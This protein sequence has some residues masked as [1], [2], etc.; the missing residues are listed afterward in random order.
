[1]SRLEN[2]SLSFDS[3]TKARR[4]AQHTMIIA[5]IESDFRPEKGFGDKVIDQY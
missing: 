1:M 2:Q 4:R 5:A 3:G